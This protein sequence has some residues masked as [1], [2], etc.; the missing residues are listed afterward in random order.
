MTDIVALLADEAQ[1]L[2]GH[3]CQGIPSD[4]LHL[5]GPD[6]VDRVMMDSDRKLG[7][8]RGFQ[9][10]IGH[11]RLAGTGYLSILPVDQGVE[12]WGAPPSPRTPSISTRRTS[13]AWRSKGAVTR[14]PPPWGC[15]ARWA[16]ATPT[17]S[18]S[19]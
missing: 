7:V 12:H 5:P 10:L 14:W 3:Q 11:G 19:W 13:C 4:L 15:W 1:D 17:R 6:F 9:T 2:L 16:G 18:P 8:L